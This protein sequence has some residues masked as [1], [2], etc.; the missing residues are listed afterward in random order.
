MKRKV[1]LTLTL[2]AA[3]F[4]AFAGVALSKAA[5]APVN[6]SPPTIS[7]TAQVGQT[8]TASTGQWESA[9]SI[10]YAYVWRRCDNNGGS[11]SNISG[12][13]DKSYTLKDVDSGN[14]LRVRV[15]ARN[16][17]GSNS[18]TSVPTGVV[19][20]KPAPP[21]TSVNGCPTSGSGAL[22]VNAVAP[23]AR[24]LIDGQQVSP[25][26]IT[27][28]AGDVTLRVHV[29]AC[30]GRPVQ[31]ALVYATGVPF[32]QFSVPPEAP[33]GADGWATLTMHQQAGFPAS[34]RQQLL[35]VF[36]RARKSGENLLGGISTRR[37]VS[38]RVSL[39]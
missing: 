29:S 4:A 7:G 8:L 5:R 11:C 27:P 3:G 13:T 14:T 18:S 12:A 22:D 15:V 39:R 19:S 36:L 2:A 28:S 34:R 26:V 10:T 24:L 1:I 31:G 17:D 38:F 21:P 32:Q 25:S 23:P 37:L 20:A 9:T 16:N 33:T 35:A 30:N 6:Q